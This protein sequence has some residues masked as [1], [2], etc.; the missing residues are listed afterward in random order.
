[1][2]RPAPLRAS[3]RATSALLA[4]RA[5]PASHAVWAPCAPRACL[6]RAASSASRL[7]DPDQFAAACLHEH[8][9]KY[10]NTKGEQHADFSRFL[11]HALGLALVDLASRR[12]EVEALRSRALA[13]SS[14]SVAHR[15]RLVADS[16]TLIGLVPPR[17]A[18]P[19]RPKTRWEPPPQEP[20]LVVKSPSFTLLPDHAEPL[21]ISFDLET[22]G[23]ET[24]T[25]RII[26]IAAM[27]CATGEVWSTLV[28]P[29]VGE[30]VPADI[31]EITSITTEMVKEPSVPIF[32]DVARQFHAVVATWEAAAELPP[33]LVAHNGRSFDTPFLVHEHRRAGLA[34]P[35]H[36]RFGDSVLLARAVLG[37][38][39]DTNPAGGNSLG[40]LV[41]YF[42]LPQLQAHRAESDARMLRDLLGPGGLGSR[43]PHLSRH[44]LQ[45]Y[46][47][48]AEEKKASYRSRR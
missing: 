3:L 14:L 4:G 15:S 10:C 26:E 48:S 28:N 29:G 42:Q 30:L 37:A 32:A 25:C 38:S 33:L 11:V 9:K 18:P 5:A 12:F 23:R 6:P 46:S 41:S 20:A 40:Q 36:W 31:T 27:N 13:Y 2:F 22:T 19:P 47:F 21:V 8:S 35:A 44:L 43:V 7:L 1:M 34:M 16:C 45:S 17:P 24:S 39:R